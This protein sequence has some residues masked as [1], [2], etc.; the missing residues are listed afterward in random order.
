MWKLLISGMINEGYIDLVYKMGVKVDNET[1]VLDS[2]VAES[3]TQP[4]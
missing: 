3:L 4:Q 2:T 1:C